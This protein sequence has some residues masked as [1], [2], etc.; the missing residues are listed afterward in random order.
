MDHGRGSRRFLTKRFSYRPSKGRNSSNG[1]ASIIKT[2]ARRWSHFL[3]LTV[4]LP[5]SW[6]SPLGQKSRNWRAKSRW[7]FSPAKFWED[8]GS[9]IGSAGAEGERSTVPGTAG[10]N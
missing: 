3:R 1:P 2:C 4:N 8:T 5:A 10:C 6:S 7:H 9:P